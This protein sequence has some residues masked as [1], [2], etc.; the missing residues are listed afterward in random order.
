MAIGGRC[1]ALFDE[2]CIPITSLPV[3]DH[4]L[5]LPVYHGLPLPKKIHA[6]Q[7]VNR[8]VSKRRQPTRNSS[9]W[10]TLKTRVAATLLLRPA[11]LACSCSLSMRWVWKVVVFAAVS[12]TIVTSSPFRRALKVKNPVWGEIA[13]GTVTLSPCS[14]GL[15]RGSLSVQPARSRELATMH[16]HCAENRAETVRSIM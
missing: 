4:G 16:T 3:Y 15:L 13:R 5:F 2:H 9:T 14:T 6:Q 7:P 10:A 1:S 8:R 11:S 12:T